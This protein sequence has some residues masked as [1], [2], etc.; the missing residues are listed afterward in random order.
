MTI[1]YRKNGFFRLDGHVDPLADGPN[2][3]IV[4]LLSDTVLT[5]SEVGPPESTTADPAR[6]ALESWAAGD[7][8]VLLPARCLVHL[9]GRAR[10]ELNHG[11]RLGVSAT[12]LRERGVPADDGA[13]FD[14]H[15]SIDRPVRRSP[16][17]ISIVFAFAGA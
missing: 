13:L 11:I 16:E 1:N 17:R 5:I 10:D 15:G 7:V 8:D 12:Q 14:W 2:V 3:C 9:S 4:G 6:V